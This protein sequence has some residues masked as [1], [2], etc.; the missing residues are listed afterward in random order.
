MAAA[1]L[2]GRGLVIVDA[3][4]KG[5]GVYQVPDGKVV[6]ALLTGP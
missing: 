4:A 2:D 3:L 5:W 6:W 1:V